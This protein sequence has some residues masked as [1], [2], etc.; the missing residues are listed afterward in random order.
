MNAANVPKTTLLNNLTV[1]VINNKLD[2]R[3]GH[4]NNKIPKY[5]K[6]W[7]EGGVIKLKNKSYTNSDN[8]GCVGMFI[9]H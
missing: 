7:G 8:R 1:I 3:Y 2:T 6:T 9:R 5:L 4:W